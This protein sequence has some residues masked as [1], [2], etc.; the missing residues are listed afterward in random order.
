M[1][2]RELVDFLMDYLGGELPENQRAVFAEHLDICPP[3]LAYLKS[4]EQTVALGR[5]VCEPDGDVPED[6]PEELVKAILAA[7]QTSS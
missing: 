6:C 1:T 2:C 4:Y 5:Q 7:R 3:C